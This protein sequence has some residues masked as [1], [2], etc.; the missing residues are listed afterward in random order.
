[1]HNNVGILTCGGLCPGLNTVIRT[2]TLKELENNNIVYGFKKGFHGLNNNIKDRLYKDDVYLINEKAGTILET[3]RERLELNDSAYSLSYLDK[4][5]CIGGNGTLA[6]G[7]LISN[8]YHNVNVIGM[9]K[10]IDNDIHQLDSFGFQTAVEETVTFIHRGYVEATSMN[11]IMFVETMGRNSGFLAAYSTKAAAGIVDFC[12]I[13]EMSP[14]TYESYRAIS[15]IYRDKGHCVVVVSEGCNYD[16]LFYA[17]N[18]EHK[19][20]KIVPGYLVRSCP[21]N[22]SDIILATNMSL[23]AVNKS[24]TMSNFIQGINNKHILF[25]EF[26]TGERKLDTDIDDDNMIDYIEHLN[27][28]M[29]RIANQNGKNDNNDFDVDFVDR[30]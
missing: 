17:L 29:S 22:V 9:A 7:K 26:Q 5:Y 27:T 21:P 23:N 25:E 13:P 10:T 12:M 14:D 20:K 4:L 28:E 18:I 24:E 16:E 15:E 1:M 19:V 11:C 8:R 2:I 6:A 30:V 3:S